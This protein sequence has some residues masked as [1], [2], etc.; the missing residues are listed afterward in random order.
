MLSS[1]GTPQKKLKT[2][3]T[4]VTF[5]HSTNKECFPNHSSSQ[6][7]S[8][9]F[10]YLI[11]RTLPLMHWTL[12]RLTRCCGFFVVIADKAAGSF[13]I[14]TPGKFPFLS[15]IILLCMPW[16]NREHKSTRREL[17]Q[18]RWR[19]QDRSTERANVW[20][21]ISR[22]PQEH[23]SVFRLP[24][25]SATHN[26]MLMHDTKIWQW[27]LSFSVLTTLTNVTTAR[28]GRLGFIS[29]PSCTEYAAI[30]LCLHRQIQRL[31]NTPRQK[32]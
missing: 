11:T 4:T 23:S 12:Q 2:T 14:E 27:R 31:V 24:Q 26:L 8:A 5:F 32:C 7:I 16:K 13:D 15:V 9:K 10:I 18:Q 20:I 25:V 19:G 22:Q 6:N 29:W 3:K 28:R 21:K 1:A 17:G 30:A